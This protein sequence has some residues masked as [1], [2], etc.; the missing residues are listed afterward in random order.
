MASSQAKVGIPYKVIEYMVTIGQDSFVC[1]YQK[2]SSTW[3]IS[4]R[5]H[6]T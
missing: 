4:K 2:P 1:K 5:G 3:L 6:P